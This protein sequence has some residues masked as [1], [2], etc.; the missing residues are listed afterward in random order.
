MG[1]RRDPG[2]VAGRPDVL[3]AAHPAALVNLEAVLGGHA[4]RLQPDPVE[5]RL[6]ADG[7]QDPFD[8]ELIAVV[9]GEAGAP[10][11][12][13]RLDQGPAGSSASSRRG[14]DSIR[15]TADPKPR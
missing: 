11:S 7:E 1:V 13:P 10:I 12:R 9:E 3:L 2:H 6:P 15:V 8:S 4:D 14:A 5:G